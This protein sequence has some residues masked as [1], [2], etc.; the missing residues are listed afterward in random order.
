MRTIWKSVLYKKVFFPFS[1]RSIIIIFLIWV[2]S[3]HLCPL[4]L[5]SFLVW[6]LFPSTFLSL[7]DHHCVHQA[8]WHRNVTCLYLPSPHRNIDSC[9]IRPGFTA[10]WENSG[11]PTYTAKT[12]PFSSIKPSPQPFSS[13]L[14]LSCSKDCKNKQMIVLAQLDLGKPLARRHFL[15]GC[16]SQKMDLI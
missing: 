2:K 5:V 6:D 3:M 12:W 16:K 10:F 4:W 8:S 11:L 9:S 13:L 7:V 14:L 1:S 15:P